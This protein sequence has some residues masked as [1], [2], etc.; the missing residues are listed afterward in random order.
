MGRTYDICFGELVCEISGWVLACNV[1]WSWLVRPQL[2]CPY[3]NPRADVYDF[4]GLAQRRKKQFVVQGQKKKM[5]SERQQQLSAGNHNW[6]F[7]R[8]DMRETYE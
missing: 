5:M 2:L 3:S 7:S 1:R 8:R 6:G 4:F